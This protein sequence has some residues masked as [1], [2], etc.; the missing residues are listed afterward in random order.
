MTIYARYI[1]VHVYRILKY[2]M[3]NNNENKILN[4]INLEFW[5]SMIA[6]SHAFPCDCSRLQRYYCLQSKLQPQA[7]VHC[8]C[9]RLD[10]YCCSK[11]ERFCSSYLFVS[12]EPVNS[13]HN[14]QC[15]WIK[16]SSIQVIA[17]GRFFSETIRES[18]K[19]TIKEIRY[20]KQSC[21]MCVLEAIYNDSLE[22][23]ILYHNIK[24]LKRKRKRN[25][26]Q[27]LELVSKLKLIEDKHQLILKKKK[28][29]FDIRFF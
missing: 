16:D 17:K 5:Y 18:K 2:Q 28:S 4:E 23:N 19:K 15:M 24:Y 8:G 25:E 1:P 21:I 10:Q 14:K 6:Q 20:A 12:S 27:N 29:F 26:E 7:V 9:S 22:L 13:I 3:K 11:S